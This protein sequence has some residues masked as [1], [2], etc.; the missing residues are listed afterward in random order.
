MFDFTEFGQDDSGISKPKKFFSDV[1]KIAEYAAARYYELDPVLDDDDEPLA[2]PGEQDAIDFLK[3]L[4]G[5]AK[6]PTPT[7]R[8]TRSVAPRAG[9]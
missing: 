8:A 1:R 9:K 4:D 6:A 7:G 2:F 3:T 5:K